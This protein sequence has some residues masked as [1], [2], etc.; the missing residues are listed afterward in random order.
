MTDARLPGYWL[1]E[2]RFTDLDDRTWRI[3]TNALMWSA[4]QA[5]DGH[6]PAKYVRKLHDTEV[7]IDDLKPLVDAD[8]FV[9]SDAGDVDMPGWSDERALRQ[10]TAASVA[11]Y[12][13]R[14]RGNQAAYRQ[15]LRE[16]LE[17]G[18]VTGH[19][20]EHVGEGSSNDSSQGASAYVGGN[21]TGHVTGNAE[22]SRYC[23]RHPNGTDQP[24][25]AC[26]DARKAAE[27]WSPAKRK[28]RARDCSVQGH[29]YAESGYCVH[30]THRNI[31]KNDEWMYR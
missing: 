27:A 29:D 2:L 10:S 23:S 11:Q 24:C 30:C 28:F 25:R 22:P 15:R 13:D 26:G 6:I 14:K 4:E 1:N 20:T 17:S 12:R 5:T 31:A 16:R 21:T 19:M 7:T 18:H 8:V 9:V 3:F